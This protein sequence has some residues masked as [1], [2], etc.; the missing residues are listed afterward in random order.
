[1][2]TLNTAAN[3][4]SNDSG[5]GSA[6][7]HRP[8]RRGLVRRT[9][10]AILVGVLLAGCA[11]GT[12]P[13]QEA[14]SLA[15]TLD[16]VDAAI[17]AGHLTT[18]RSDV[19]TLITQTNQARQRGDITPSQADQILAAA[20]SVLAQLPGATAKPSA[21]S[22]PSASPSQPSP[23]TTQ[24]GQGG[25]NSGPGAGK[26]P[27]PAKKHPQKPVGPGDDKKG[28]GKADNGQGDGG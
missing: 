13:G 26:K 15:S 5:Y 12:P 21:S 8:G 17:A 6:V 20:R 3:R 19:R 11:Q 22:I 2:V 16:R 18:A 7:D 4:T 27:K 24:P 9:V 23:S 25:V 28:G 1:M 10:A 14:P